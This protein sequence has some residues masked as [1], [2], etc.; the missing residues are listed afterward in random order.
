MLAIPTHIVPGEL[1]EKLKA[2][3]AVGFDAIDLSLSDVAQFDGD[4]SALA[5]LVEK[6]GLN[7]VS[8]GAV[9]SGAS[10][11]LIRAKI[12]MAQTLGADILILDIKDEVPTNLPS[13]VGVR[14]ALRPTRA[15]E[16]A[17]LAYIAA[18]DDPQIGLAPVSYT[19][20]TLPTIYSV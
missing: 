6:A 13:P 7:I 1:A 12:E 18:E 10:A 2:I 15:T 5:D 8:L 17:V 11:A 20:L 4:L 16:A 14:L 3:A 19:H 9:P